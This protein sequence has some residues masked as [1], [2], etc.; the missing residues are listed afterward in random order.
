[1]KNREGVRKCASIFSRECHQEYRLCF[2]RSGSAVWRDSGADPVN[3]RQIFRRPIVPDTMFQRDRHETSD[4]TINTVEN[5]IENFSSSL[6]YRIRVCHDHRNRCRTEESDFSTA[7]FVLVS[8]SLHAGTTSCGCTGTLTQL[9]REEI[10]GRFMV[11]VQ[12]ER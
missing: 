1:M 12:R 6:F 3:H 7:V 8:L 9:W 11:K 2:Q 10:G 4:R 5:S